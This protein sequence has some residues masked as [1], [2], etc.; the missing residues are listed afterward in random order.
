MIVSPQ[1]PPLIQNLFVLGF[2]LIVGS[3]TNVLVHRVPR[4]ESIVTPRSRCP[5]CQKLI[6]WYDNL[7]VLSYLLLRGQCR[8]CQT[9]IS[10]RYPLI[11]LLTA[12]LFLAAKQRFGW[13]WLLLVRDFPFLTLLV[14]IT[15][16]DLEHRIIPDEMSLGG[17]VLGVATSWAVPELGLVQSLIGAALGFGVFY[18]F[19][20]AYYKYSGRVGLGGGDVKLLAMLGAFLG[21]QAIF[22]TILISSIVGSLVG[23]FWALIT[24]RQRIMQVAI[25]YGPF[26]VVGALYFYLIGELLWLPFG[27]HYASHL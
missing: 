8:S 20:W 4:G 17:L 18:G 5:G 21:P 3:F 19:S 6:P 16:I 12:I 23:I 14:A 2:G 7:P 15:F 26:L 13:G 9:K 10:I 1:I 25:P 27:N 11:E 22:V 24:R